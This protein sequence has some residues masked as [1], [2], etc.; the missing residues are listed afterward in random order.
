MRKLHPHPLKKV[1]P[2]FPATPS[3]SQGTPL[4]KMWLKV[5][6]PSRKWGAHYVKKVTFFT[7]K[8]PH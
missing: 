3:K 8:S 4:S 6:P 1:T 2:S 7:E 5:Q